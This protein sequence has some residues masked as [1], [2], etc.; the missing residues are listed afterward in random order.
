[1]NGQRRSLRLVST[2][3][4]LL[5]PSLYPSP[6]H[7]P[8]TFQERTGNP[9]SL[10]FFPYFPLSR[11][12][13]AFLGLIHRPFWACHTTREQSQVR[14]MWLRRGLIA[15]PHP[16]LDPSLPVPHH[17]REKFRLNLCWNFSQF[18][19]GAGGSMQASVEKLAAGEKRCVRGRRIVRFWCCWHWHAWGSPYGRVR[20]LGVIPLSK[21]LIGCATTALRNTVSLGLRHLDRPSCSCLSCRS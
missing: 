9:G 16:V 17:E 11:P 19:V 14:R 13:L 21:T 8:E 18:L 20:R 4:R 7:L 1:M 3:S 5:P 6:G 15:G 2:L 10:C 12:I